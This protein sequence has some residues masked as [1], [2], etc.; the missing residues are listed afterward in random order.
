MIDITS[1]DTVKQQL[2]FLG[3]LTANEQQ[4]FLQNTLLIRYKKGHVIHGGDTECVG[5][6]LL[7]KGILRTYM[8]S[9]SGREITLYRLYDGDVCVLSASCILRQITFDVHIDAETDSEVLLVSAPAV[10]ALIESN[11]SVENF[12]YKQAADRFFGCHVDHAAGFV[13]GV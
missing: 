13:H 8:L 1:F 4:Q 10:A 3:S 2:P 12:V 9:E 7:T 6:L 11:I 5:L